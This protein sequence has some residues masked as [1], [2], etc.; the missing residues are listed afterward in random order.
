MRAGEIVAAMEAYCAAG[1]Y[2]RAF[3]A[4]ESDMGRHLVTENAGFFN[5][6]FKSCPEAILERH[7]GAAF[8]YAIAAFSASDFSS[9]DGQLAWLTEKCTALPHGQEADTWRGELEFLH[10]LAAFNDIEAMSVHHRRANFLL[11]R[12]TGLFGKNASWTLGSPS[13]LFM[14]YRE[15]GK[16][17]EEVRRM[18][19]CLP[20]YYQLASYH[21][22]G[23]ELLMEAEALYNAGRFAEAEILCHRGEAMAGHH[24]QLGNMICAVFLRLR[25]AL[26]SGEAEKAQGLVTAMH[27]LIAQSRDYFLLHTVDMCVGWLYAALRRPEK[28]P[29]WLRSE[30]TE[31][32]RL[33]AFAKGWYYIVHGR[34]LL[35]GKE[36]ARVL[37]L[38]GYL[39]EKG[40]FRKHLLFSIYAHIYLAAAYQGQGKAVQAAEAFG[41]A[42]DVALPDEVYMPFAENYDLLAPVFKVKKRGRP[43]KRLKTALVL[44]EQMEACRRAIIDKISDQRPLGFTSR[45]Y[46][47]ALLMAEGLPSDEIAQRL[48]ISLNTVKFHL[49][50]VYRKTGAASRLALKKMLES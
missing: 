28:M 45:E 50:N 10:S 47:T 32:S 7:L 18:H 3:A 38:F 17:N 20:H 26:V 23:G 8:K 35:L 48:H 33:Y 39:L 36:Y 24:A 21:G 46:E 22:A 43:G 19:D 25:L 31:G 27:S 42:L 4:L 6:M 41:Y 40:L 12:P 1:E 29:A 30:L 44:A 13:V 9:F 5:E 16:L 2:D 14:F 37:G 34:A 49:K 15:S 11:G